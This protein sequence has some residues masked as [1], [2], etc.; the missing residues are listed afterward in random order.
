MA[1]PIYD[2]IPELGTQAQAIAR[3]RKIA[4]MMMA[5]GQ[6]QQPANQMAGQVVAPVSWTQGLAQ[7]ANAYLGKKQ[8]EDADKQE[9]GLANQREKMVADALTQFKNTAQG[10]AGV[11]GIAAQPERTIQAPAPMQP[12][13]V[14]PNYNTVPEIVPAVAGREAI[15]A[16]KGDKRQAIMQAVMSNLPEVQKYGTAMLGFEEMDIKNSQLEAARQQAIE[17]KQLDREARMAEIQ[18]QIDSR[19]MMG[20]Q[21]NDL[22]AAMANLQAETR[23]DAVRLAAS[24][25]PAPAEKAPIQITDEAGNVKL[26]DYQGNLVKDLGKVGKPT[27]GYQKENIAKKKATNDIDLT[28]SEL[29]SASKDGGL[30]DQSTGSGAG[31]LVDMAGDFIGSPTKGSIAVGRMKPIY[32]MALKM[33]PRFEGPQ[34]DKDTASYKEAAGNLANPNVPNETKKSAAKEIVRLMKAR[35]NQFIDKSNEGTEI[36]TGILNTNKPTSGLSIDDRLKKYK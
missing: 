11:E 25:R 22:R 34:S 20:Q 4:E 1:L 35:K 15:P 2:N 10:T 8:A 7:L 29:E 17:Q 3:R 26:V 36:D 23:L 16:V 28:I 9:Q 12:N 13:Q 5:R 24:L 31:A 18:A 27:A 32:D 21:T 30:I 33:V 14:A 19:E 6:E